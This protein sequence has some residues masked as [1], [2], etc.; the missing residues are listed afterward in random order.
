MKEKS[1]EFEEK[2]RRFEEKNQVKNTENCINLMAKNSRLFLVF[3]STF[4]ER[5]QSRIF[6]PKAHEGMNKN[7][8][9]VEGVKNLS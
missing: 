7:K 1:R 6:W 3:C 8:G 5:I 9:E 4:G 2:S